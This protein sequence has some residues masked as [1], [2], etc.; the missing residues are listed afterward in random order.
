MG[1]DADCAD[2]Q[3]TLFF[4]F[5]CSFFAEDCVAPLML[6]G[7]RFEHKKALR[8][9]QWR[10]VRWRGAWRCTGE[11]WLGMWPDSH[12][13]DTNTAKSGRADK[14]V[15]AKEREGKKRA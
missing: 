3:S 10:V 5:Y 8:G 7:C 11:R 4:F 15:K 13:H 14:D 1:W 2:V 12:D 6:I 9:C